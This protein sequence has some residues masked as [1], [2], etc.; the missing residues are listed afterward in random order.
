MTLTSKFFPYKCIDC[1]R[2]YRIIR[3]DDLYRRR[4][5]VYCG[6]CKKVY[7]ITLNKKQSRYGTRIVYED[8]NAEEHEKAPCKHCRGYIRKHPNLEEPA[9]GYCEYYKGQICINCGSTKVK[10][11]EF[12]P[13]K[14]DPL[15]DKPITQIIKSSVKRLMK[16]L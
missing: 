6:K 7:L 5:S 11:K 13:P 9:E 2:Q 8:P 16:E 4:E 14:T 12:Q 15:D 10:I 1:K 3:D